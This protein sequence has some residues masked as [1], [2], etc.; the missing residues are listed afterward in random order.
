MF[1][2]K[3][4]TPPLCKVV[5]DAGVVVGDV[6]AAAEAEE[7]DVNVDG[8]L[9]RVMT[10]DDGVGLHVVLEVLAQELFEHNFHVAASC[11]HG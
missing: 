5:E 7:V 9:L 8:G 2:T 3:K 11:H 4:L 1:V 10:E 6:H